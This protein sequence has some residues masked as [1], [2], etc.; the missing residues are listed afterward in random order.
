MFG[1][2]A[3]T[4]DGL[5]E[6]MDWLVS[7][8]KNPKHAARMKEIAEENEQKAQKQDQDKKDK[9]DKE[10][11]DKDKDKEEQKEQKKGVLKLEEWME[12]KDEDDDEFLK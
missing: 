4:G 11:K 3:T 6:M 7:T 12:R 1:A 2:C 9:E 5:Y 8:L 10:D